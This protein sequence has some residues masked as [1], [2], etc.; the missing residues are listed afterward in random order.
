MEI[1]QASPRHCASYD[2]SKR[3]ML[4]GDDDDMG[5]M[6]LIKNEAQ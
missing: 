6:E 1:K 3:I 4:V 2:L 5:S